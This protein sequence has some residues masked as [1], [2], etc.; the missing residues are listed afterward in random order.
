[1]EKPTMPSVRPWKLL[2]HT[3]ISACPAGTPRAS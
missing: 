1:M 3:M 2:A